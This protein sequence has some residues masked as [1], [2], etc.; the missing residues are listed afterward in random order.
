MSTIASGSPP[1]VLPVETI[2]AGFPSLSRTHNHYPVAYFDGPG[3]TQVPRAVVEAMADYLYHHNANTHWAYPS[4]V[5]TDQMIDRARSGFADFFNCRPNEIVF[6]LNMTTLAFH[7]ARGLGRAWQP[8]DEVVVTEL[9]HHGNVA[10]WQAL[11]RD[12][13][14]VI[15]TLPLRVEDGGVDLGGLE[16]V[17]GPRTRL[18]AVTAASNSLGTILDVSAACTLARQAGILSFVDAVHAAPHILLDVQAIGCDFLACS[19]YKFYGPHVGV[20][21]GREA[22]L[23]ELEIPKV[24]PA[25]DTVPGTDRNRDPES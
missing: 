10:P 19:A 11:E 4:S 14:I 22:L 17:I 23:A 13:G 24:A 18:L 5:E 1:R 7:V 3:G 12:R 6:G 15:R 16:R 9:E 25:P 8:G 2:R 21:F 20:L